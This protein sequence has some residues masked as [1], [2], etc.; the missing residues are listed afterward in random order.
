[1]NMKRNFLSIIMKIA[2]LVSVSVLFFANFGYCIDISNDPMDTKVQAAPP[3][4]MFVFDNSGSMDWEFMTQENDGTFRVK[5]TLYLY[6]FNDP[7]DNVY[8]SGYILSGSARAYWKSQWS[9]YNKLYYNPHSIYKP[10]PKMSNA[11]TTYPW[12]NPVNHASGDP[13]ID[14]SAE[15][16]SYTSPEVSVIVDNNDAGFSLSSLGWTLHGNDGDSY[17]SNYYYSNNGN[18]GTSWAKWT[19]TFSSAGE[20]E[21][22]GW[23]RSGINARVTDASYEIYHNGSTDT[24]CCYNQRINGGQWNSLGTYEFSA[25]GS[26][27]VKLTAT[28]TGE[29]KYCADAIKFLKSGSGVQ[30]SIK[31][32]HYY[33]VNDVNNNGSYDSG[34]DIYLVTWEDSDSDGKLDHRLYYKISGAGDTIESGD[35]THVDPGDVPNSVKSAVYK[36]DGTLD[37]YMTD[38]E[39]LQNFANWYSYYRRRELAAKAA[40]ANSIIDLSWVNVGFYTINSGVRQTVLPVNVD[41]NAIIVDNKDSG[42]LEHGVWNESSVSN[43]YNDSSRY[44][45]AIG[46]WAK[47]TP[48][49]PETKKYKVYAWW[50]YYSNRD[51]NALYTIHYN[52]GTDNI[53]VNQRDSATSNQWVLLGTYSF[54]KGSTGY[55]QVTRDHNS[56]GKSTSADAVKFE[57]ASGG[58][59]IDRTDTLLN[60]LYSIDSHNGTPLRKALLNVGR[61]Y[62]QTDGY[63]GNLG[64]SPYLSASQG[65]ECQQAFTIVMTDG[66]WNGGSPNVGNQDGNKGAPYQDPYPNTLA[67][68]AMKYYNKDLSTTLDNHVPTNSY[69]KKKTQHMVTYAISFGVKGSIDPL[70]INGDGVPD[71]PSY[72]DDPYFLNPATPRPVWPDPRPSNAS[73]AKIDDLWHAAVNGRGS[74]FSADNPQA[75]VEALQ[76]VFKNLKARLASGASVSVNGDEL[77]TGTVVYQSTYRSGQWTGDV[78]AFPVNPITGEILKEAGDIKWKASD[79]LQS[80]DWSADRKIITSDGKGTG[81]PFLYTSL[82]TGQKDALDDNSDVVDYIRGEEISG[83]RQRKKKLGDIVHSA[84]LLVIKDG[85]DNNNNGLVDESGEA[86]GT[87]FVGSNDGMVHAFNAK[88]GVERFAYIPHLVFDHLMDLT[89]VNYSH[90]FYVDSTPYAAAIRFAAGDMSKDGIDNDGDGQIDEADENY[91]DS[92]DNDGNGVVDEAGEYKT[93]VVLVGGLGKGGKGYYALDITDMESIDSSKSES[94]IKDMVMWE[95]PPLTNTD[96]VYAG[97]QTHDGIDNNNNGVVDDSGENYSD[98]IDNNGDGNIDEQ[99]EKKFKYNDN[100]MGYSFSKAFI[101]KSYISMNPSSETN[102]PWVVIFGNGYNSV[103]GHAVLYVLNALTGSLIRKIDTGVGGDNGLSSPA[104]VDINNDGRADYVYAGDLKGN[105][106]KFDITESD[107]AKWGVAFGVDGSGNGRIDGTETGD[108]PKPLFSSPGQPITVAPDV[109]FHCEG[110]G[111]MVLYGTG[112]FLGETDR[113]NQ[114]K[115]TIYG[116]WDFGGGQSDYLGTWNETTGTL[117]NL[118]LTTKETL[119]KQTVVDSRYLNNYYLRT[120]SDNHAD[121]SLCHNKKDDND[122]SVI[123]DSGEC[124]THAGWYFDL[125]L[126]GERVIEDGMIRDGNLVIITFIPNDSPCSGGGMSIVH[127]M[128]ACDGSRLTAPQFDINNDG[129]VDDNDLITITDVN[130]HTIKVPPTGKGYD[131][132]LHPPVIVSMPDKKREMKIL[133][134]SKGTTETLFEK[135]EPI[136]MFYWRES[137]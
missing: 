42:Y 88:T 38:A 99:G 82:T 29:S 45:K 79:E 108:V 92:V 16:Y 75:L 112:K 117:S 27:Y 37:H 74:F 137:D 105:M 72:A 64:T 7:G 9:G 18:T 100:D 132:Q 77:N 40:V 34:E 30:I 130:G 51:S 50:D 123:D 95:Y 70:D 54:A 120:L 89:N 125:P 104:I 84:P 96:F 93:K 20:Y 94:D 66:Y 41:T 44:T 86:D 60:L 12:S 106:W 90:R 68:V 15:Y 11:D 127:E 116:I 121:W 107:P 62:D 56:T 73:S 19:P 111:Y 87:I 21:I 83:F 101:V 109:M 25:D 69:D 114:D 63:D 81:L 61:Y 135:A 3:N 113:S 13:H 23:W 58:I 49:I 131:G 133:S 134:S 78:V 129:K 35:I 10:W 91:S 110:D 102:H 55:V 98:G 33:V 43:E 36:E 2:V 6:L 32:A 103:N 124:G 31:N 53:R 71:D 24:S 128:N 26:E 80:M 136:G 67:D 22:F 85:K 5:N 59:N 28:T 119:L 97:D 17:G 47:W 126:A 4:I 8:W 76:K 65:G 115:Q 46:N 39:E 57:P 118:A 122:D 1:M 48:Y 14:L 52:G